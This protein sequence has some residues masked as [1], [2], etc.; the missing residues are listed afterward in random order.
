M[1][2]S[3]RRALG[4]EITSNLEGANVP[5]TVAAVEEFRDADIGRLLLS[6]LRIVCDGNDYVAHRTLLGVRDGVGIGTCNAICEAVIGAGGL[7]YRRIFY[8]P[9]PGGVF[10][11][12]ALRALN[13]ART[14]CAQI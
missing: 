1:L 9:L 11:A 14:V 4:P 10:S 7:N 8:D 3:N 2:L 12:R 5:F 6:I 13:A